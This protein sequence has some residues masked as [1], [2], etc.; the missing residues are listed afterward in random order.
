[1][2]EPLEGRYLLAVTVVPQPP[3]V[4]APPAFFDQAVPSAPSVPAVPT[5]PNFLTAPPQ[6]PSDLLL[7]TARGQQIENKLRAIQVDYL[8]GTLTSTGVTTIDLAGGAYQADLDTL[9]APQLETASGL[10]TSSAVGSPIDG[11]VDDTGPSVL[12]FDGIANVNDTLSLDLG[13]LPRA[14]DGDLSV[15][16]IIYHGGASGYDTLKL[17]GGHFHQVAYLPT[18]KDSGVLAYDDLTIVFDGLEPVIDTTTDDWIVSYG[19]G[20][21]DSIYAVDGGQDASGDNLVRVYEANTNFEEVSFANKTRMLI[22]SMGGDAEHQARS[23][24]DAVVGTQYRRT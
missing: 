14:A 6:L 13:A 3:A 4:P 8:S 9:A 20:S 10:Q 11:L 22:A 16:T 23:R 19:T 21:A 5:P 17:S 1:V 24:N 7:Q 15:S 12:E 18:G 2:I